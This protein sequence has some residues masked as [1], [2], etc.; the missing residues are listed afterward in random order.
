VT[1]LVPAV[2]DAMQRALAATLHDIFIFVLLIA[3]I[4]AGVAFLFPR[5]RA[6]ELQHGGVA[7]ERGESSARP[8]ETTPVVEEG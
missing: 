4:A 8:V 3:V 1:A 7:Q 2:L 6:H 5:G